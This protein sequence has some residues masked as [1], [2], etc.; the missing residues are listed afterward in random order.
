LHTNLTSYKQME[1][2]IKQSWWKRNW[3]WALPTGGCLTL[4]I[5]AVAFISYGVYKVS[6]KLTE[7]TSF[8]AF[9]GVIQEVQKSAEV[10]E[11]LGAPIR[12]NG[13]DDGSALDNSERLDLDFEIQGAEQNGQLRVVA[14]KTEEGWN[15]TTFTITALETGEIIDL[16][17]QANE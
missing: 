3:K 10:R 11:A 12:F 2:E 1:P 7:E 13:M 5:I 9:F 14:E 16:K 4:I 17:D 8:F 6:D 15:Y